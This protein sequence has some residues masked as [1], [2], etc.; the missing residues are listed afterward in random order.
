[1]LLFA[2]TPAIA[3]MLAMT[4]GS[5][6]NTSASQ[7]AADTKQVLFVLVL[8][9]LWC[10]STMSIREVVKELPIL[11]HEMRFGVRLGPYILS[12]FVL[13]GLFSLVQ[14]L[15]LLWMVKFFTELSGPFG[16]QYAILGCT[17]LVGIA[18]GLLV[19]ASSG[20]SERAMTLLP[21]LLIAQAIFSGGLAR[22]SGAV[23]LFSM[24]L[25]PAY[26][27]MEGLKAPLGP[28]R[29]ERYVG[30]S[31]HYQD[32]ILGQGKNIMIAEFVI[33]MHLAMLLALTYWVLRLQ[34]RDAGR[35]PGP[36][37]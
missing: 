20:N 1:M 30:E 10:S 15:I 11:R 24:I 26:W 16:L 34:V 36:A 18:L 27:A 2:Q 32:F 29:D 14:A 35:R 9:V 33:F 6:K 28:L 31:G 3:L 13:L 23:E 4:F 37:A 19:S 17:S 8:A 7:E 12:K 22:L 21:V 5:I 25:V